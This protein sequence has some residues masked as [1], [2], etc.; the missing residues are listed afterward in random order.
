MLSAWA[1]GDDVGPNGEP[2]GENAWQAHL[3][4]RLVAEIDQPVIAT[5]A[6]SRRDGQLAGLRGGPVPGV[7]E[8]VAV[9]APSQLD[10]QLLRLLDALDAHHQVELLL[11]RPT[12][13]RRPAALNGELRRADFTRPAGH[14]LNRAL[15]QL[16]DEAAALVPGE[17]TTEPLP[18]PSSE[19][20]LLRRLQSNLRSDTEPAPGVLAPSDDSIQVH[21]SHD[22]SRQVEVLREVLTDLLAS[23]PSLEPRD[24]AVF[25]P[26]VDAVAPLIGA[27]FSAAS[28][29]AH[30]A[31]AS[32]AAGHRSMA[33]VNQWSL[34][35]DCSRSRTDVSRRPPFSSSARIQRSRP[36]PPPGRGVWSP[37]SQGRCAL[38]PVRTALGVRVAGFPRTLVRGSPAHA[39]RRSPKPI[40]YRQAR[41]CAI[42]EPFDGC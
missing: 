27:A 37:G 22:L 15:G 20:T 4:R 29:Q 40:W 35:P 34:L 41:C 38:G 10:A 5:E 33:Q 9:L 18:E 6:L 8:R 42:M 17:E 25:T 12:P 2:L 13:T 14:R 30:P 16:A 21:L 23:D 31:S 1:D 26:D 11:L 39:G 28:G 7:P 32:G 3:W 36:A 24:I 19:R